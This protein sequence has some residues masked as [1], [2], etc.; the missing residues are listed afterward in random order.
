MEEDIRPAI[1]R[2]IMLGAAE[3]L[4][5]DMEGLDLKRGAGLGPD[6]Y[7]ERVRFT[8]DDGTSRFQ[9]VGLFQKRQ[10]AL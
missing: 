9:K 5:E 7:K 4:L 1:D 6:T 3:R 8:E 10:T 2:G